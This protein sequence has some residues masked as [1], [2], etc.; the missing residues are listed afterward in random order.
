MPAIERLLVLA[1]K[2]Y[3]WWDA[4]DQFYTLRALTLS[5]HLTRLQEALLMLAE[6]VAKVT[7]N[8]TNPPGPFDADTGWWIGA[9]VRDIATEIGDPVFTEAAWKTLAGRAVS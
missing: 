6:N 8:A 4:K 3:L 1:G 9:N 7:Y 2:R 5:P